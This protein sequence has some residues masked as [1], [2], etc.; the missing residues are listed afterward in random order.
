M[1]L[2]EFFKINGIDVGFGSHPIEGTVYSD[3]KALTSEVVVRKGKLR[4]NL[5]TP[6][7]ELTEAFHNGM[8][9]EPAQV[10][11]I[12]LVTYSDLAIPGGRYD[13]KIECPYGKRF[14]GFE[15]YGF[16]ITARFYGTIDVQEGQ[17]YIKG[18][19]RPEYEGNEGAV[20]IEIVKH[21][22]PKPLLPERESLTL[23][24]ALKRNPLEV[25]DLRIGK[26]AFSSFPEKVLSF[27]NLERL[28]IGGQANL[29]FET[30]PDAFFQLTSLHTVQIYGGFKRS[31]LKLLSPTI[32]R[33][34]HLEELTIQAANLIEIPEE[35]T[36]LTNLREIS[37][38]NNQLTSL[39]ESIGR[40]PH[41]SA[42]DIEGNR[43][44]SLPKSLAEIP[45]VRVDR[46]YK[47]LYM[48]TAYNSKNP[49]PM[50]ESLF[51]LTRYPQ[52]REQLA[53]E[54]DKNEE[55][56]AYKDFLL[57]T[58][59]IGTY[60]M[61]DDD[62]QEIPLGTSKVGGAPD[63]PEDW[64]HPAGKNGALY[65]FHAQ[66]NCEE[67]A[68]FQHYLPRTGM[69]YFFVSDEEHVDKTIV[70]YAHA[71]SGLKRHEYNEET[72]FTDPDFDDN[73]RKAVAVKFAN[74]VSLPST[75]NL[76]HHGEERFPK[77]AGYLESLKK[78]DAAY[79]H[80]EDNVTEFVEQLLEKH[81]SIGHKGP[82]RNFR[83]HSLN[84]YVFTQ[85][86]SPEEQAAA[87]FGGEPSEWMVLLNME[88]IGKF[89]FWDAG[90]LTYCIH[91]KDLAIADF[92]RV[93]T[94][95]ESS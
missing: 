91:K 60:L 46:K 20:P 83:T 74:A 34:T 33:L 67:A 10:D 84:S 65:L 2:Q 38:R 27:K 90:T 89:S 71:F 42:L 4:I 18:E 45:S 13:T 64:A 62:L 5:L 44:R 1:I 50:D 56:K 68:P 88:S 21:F 14:S 17:V 30:L 32:S 57:G 55:V 70:L 22:D 29:E 7:L 85:H 58:A 75:Y 36:S 25:Y 37:F 77:Y 12:R 6:A 41:L 61:L 79:G 16:P 23:E 94:S 48:D 49:D 63:L 40:L 24:E 66:I 9:E 28:W 35:I 78:D 54:I 51:D 59:R 87:R 19:L 43:F 39:P 86:E 69:L 31:T 95:I 52:E 82:Y 53:N 73:Y 8:L 47:K 26:G 93:H 11:W 80:F 92:G 76:Y 72:E 81:E 3:P 15:V